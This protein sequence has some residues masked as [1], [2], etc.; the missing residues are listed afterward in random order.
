M[1]VFKC[2]F[3]DDVDLL[4]LDPTQA[5]VIWD[6]VATFRGILEK[7]EPTDNSTSCKTQNCASEQSSPSNLDHS[8]DS[9]QPPPNKRTG[10]NSREFEI[11]LYN[12]LQRYYSTNQQRRL[13]LADSVGKVYYDLRFRLQ[14][15]CET[16]NVIPSVTTDNKEDQNFSYKQFGKFLVSV[17]SSE[18]TKAEAFKLIDRNKSAGSRPLSVKTLEKIINENYFSLGL[19]AGRAKSDIALDIS[20]IVVDRIQPLTVRELHL[21]ALGSLIGQQISREKSILFDSAFEQLQR[22]REKVVDSMVELTEINLEHHESLAAFDGLCRQV[23]YATVIPDAYIFKQSTI[24]TRSTLASNNPKSGIEDKNESEFWLEQLLDFD[25]RK[26]LHRTPEKSHSFNVVSPSNSARISAIKAYCQQILDSEAD[27]TARITAKLQWQTEWTKL[28][29]GIAN[30]KQQDSAS[31]VLRQHFMLARGMLE[32][33]MLAAYRFYVNASPDESER[34]KRILRAIKAMGAE[35]ARMRQAISQTDPFANFVLADI[36]FHMAIPTILQKDGK[37]FLP[38]TQSEMEKYLSFSLLGRDKLRFK[39][40]VGRSEIIKEHEQI[41]KR[42]AKYL[43]FR[44][45]TRPF[46]HLESHKDEATYHAT[47]ENDLI[48]TKEVA[49]TLGKHL[50]KAIHDESRSSL[51]QAGN[52]NNIAQ[53]QE[54]ALLFD[55]MLSQGFEFNPI[56]LWE[57]GEID[58]LI[59]LSDCFPPKELVLSAGLGNDNLSL[60]ADQVRLILAIENVLEK[61][62]KTGGKQNSLIPPSMAIFVSTEEFIKRLLDEKLVDKSRLDNVYKNGLY[63]CRAYVEEFKKEVRELFSQLS[64]KTLRERIIGHFGEDKDDIRTKLNKFLKGS[65]SHPAKESTNRLESVLDS[66]RVFDLH[67]AI[68]RQFIIEAGGTVAWHLNGNNLIYTYRQDGNEGVSRVVDTRGDRR[69]EIFELIYSMV[70]DDQKSEKNGTAREFMDVLKGAK[71]AELLRCAADIYQSS[72]L[73]SDSNSI[74]TALAYAN[75]QAS[76]VCI[77]ALIVFMISPIIERHP[78]QFKKAVAY[79]KCRSAHEKPAYENT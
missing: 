36:L 25:C 24:S 70:D 19:V 57:R 40:E 53:L 6:L 42:I 21:C 45:D 65:G 7:L 27:E 74:P 31:L 38:T 78:D 13:A 2:Q 22:I 18:K 29:E 52:G 56:Q 4:G 67:P 23:T 69:F 54:T 77:A 16:P 72:S 76:K 51:S 59:F 39:N 60:M 11:A 9:P 79:W 47:E 41:L 34:E 44:G 71:T 49:V 33:Q 61:S 12:V 68:H 20:D 58:R 50:F 62:R 55:C 43:G 28:I 1:L 14:Q 35:I 17:F 46:T 73:D 37:E 75:P 30:Q 64:D 5:V 48:T 10:L 8:G 63:N 3:F 32:V 26:L 15:L 66:I